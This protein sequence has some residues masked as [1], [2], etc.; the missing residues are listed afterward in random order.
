MTSFISTGV[1]LSVGSVV[2]FTDV[3]FSEGILNLSTFKSTGK[4]VC[5]KSGLY[6]VSVSIEFSI[7]DSEF[8]I[9]VNG[10]IFTK[11]YKHQQG[12][13]WHS[14]SSVIAIELNTNDNVWVQI[15][16]VNA[17]LRADLHSRFTVIKIK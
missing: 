14:S 9:Y 6:I 17:N 2:K 10:K 5:E 4:C 16:G 13:W 12:N 1:S 3:K 11:N 7:N 15:G 8:Y